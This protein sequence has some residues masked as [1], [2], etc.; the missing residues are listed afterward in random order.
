MLSP[1]SLVA[2]AVQP[3]AP[4]GRPIEWIVTTTVKTAIGLVIAMIASR[5]LRGVRSSLELGS[6]GIRDH[7]D[8]EDRTCRRFA[9][10]GHGRP[11]RHRARTA[12]AP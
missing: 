4:I 12:L 9:D 2:S 7:R 10:V 3:L 6:H 11:Q 8:F 1:I 5:L